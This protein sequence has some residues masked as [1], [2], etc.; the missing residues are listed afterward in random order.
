ME[1]MKI[2][3]H[4]R[5]KEI[6]IECYGRNQGTAKINLFAVVF[7][8]CGSVWFDYNWWA[9]LVLRRWAIGG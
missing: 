6:K 9:C 8:F 1:R 7:D 4:H 5:S 3:S 2:L